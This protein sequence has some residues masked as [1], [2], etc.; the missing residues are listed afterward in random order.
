MYKNV[1]LRP[2]TSYR[3]LK[4]NYFREDSFSNAYV[5]FCHVAESA[6]KWTMA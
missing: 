4:I 3:F 1:G 2:V 5:G 6:H